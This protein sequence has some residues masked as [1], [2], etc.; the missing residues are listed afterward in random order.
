MAFD[1]VKYLENNKIEMGSI[2]KEVG[3]HI[4]KSGH[5]DLRKTTYDVNIVDGKFDLHTHKTVMTESSESI[6]E[7]KLPLNEKFSSAQE[8][9]LRDIYLASKK[10]QSTLNDSQMRE[11]FETAK[12]LYKN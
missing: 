7:V 3:T 1:I 10:Y 5:N 12:R 8:K 6:N 4:S 11:V 2:K 9:F